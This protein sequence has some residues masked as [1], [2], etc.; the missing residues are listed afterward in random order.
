MVIAN[1]KVVSIHYTLRNDAGEVVDSSAGGEPLDYLH[2]CGHIVKGLE[3]ALDGLATGASIDVEVTPAEGYGEHHAQLVQQVPRS[4]FGDAIDLEVGMR[5][6]AEGP[7]GE[8]LVVITALGD[9]E[10]TIDGNHPL[11][12]QTLAFAV[13]VAAVRDATAEEVEHG[14]A[15]GSGHSHG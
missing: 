10:V 14:H 11:A 1:G 7:Q 5:F 4:A 8:Q 12:G 2:G 13:E 3:D 9:D 6:R 15:H